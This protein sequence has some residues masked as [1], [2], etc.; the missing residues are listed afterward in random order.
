MLEISCWFFLFFWPHVLINCINKLV[1]EDV[2]CHLWVLLL[3]MKT[4]IT[5]TFFV[6]FFSLKIVF[7]FDRRW[8]QN[9]RYVWEGSQS[10]KVQCLCRDCTTYS[11]FI[12]LINSSEGEALKLLKYIYIY[13]YIYSVW[14]IDRAVICSWHSIC[15]PAR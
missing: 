9:G 5:K 11:I 12:Q 7:T 8:K 13:I 10:C 15:Y 2:W 1:L 4:K 3:I 14:Q 6:H